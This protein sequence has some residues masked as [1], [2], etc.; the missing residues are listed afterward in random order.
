MT[1]LH[2]LWTGAVTKVARGAEP[3]VTLAP[4][5]GHMSA[6]TNWWVRAEGESGR[7]QSEPRRAQSKDYPLPQRGKYPTNAHVYVRETSICTSRKLDKNRGI[8]EELLKSRGKKY[9]CFCV[10][11]RKTKNATV[12]R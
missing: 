8:N 10:M 3:V 7:A 12:F 6:W 9:K 2:D 4:R 1:H 11:K 5:G